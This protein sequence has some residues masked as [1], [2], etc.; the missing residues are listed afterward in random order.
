MNKSLFYTYTVYKR[1]LVKYCLN[2]YMSVSCP[3]NENPSEIDKNTEK[4]C[5][6]TSHCVFIFS[7]LSHIKKKNSREHMQ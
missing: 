2:V 4:C 5:E 1:M 7:F 6:Y 3:V